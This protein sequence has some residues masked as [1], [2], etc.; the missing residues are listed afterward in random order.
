MAQLLK[1]ESDMTQKTKEDDYTQCPACHGSGK[2]DDN[3]I[4]F[5]CNGTGKRQQACTVPEGPEHEGVC[6]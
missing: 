5:E 4:C 6:D 2:N 3:T 1:E